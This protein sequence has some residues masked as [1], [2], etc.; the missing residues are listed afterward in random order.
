M[1]TVAR[2]KSGTVAIDVHLFWTCHLPLKNIFPF[3]L[4]PAKL[5]GDYFDNRWC[6]SNST[7]IHTTRQF[8]YAMFGAWRETRPEQ[9]KKSASLKLIPNSRCKFDPHRHWR[10]RLRWV[11][12]MAQ[13]WVLHIYN[14]RIYWRTEI[15]CVWLIDKVIAYSGCCYKRKKK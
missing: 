8:I 11:N 5:K 7:V 15:L 13:R 4:S 10:R 2:H 6:G 3:P 12:T 9:E 1:F 14:A